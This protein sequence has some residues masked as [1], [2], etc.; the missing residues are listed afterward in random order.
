MLDPNS[1]V[2]ILVAM[3]QKRP[4]KQIALAAAFGASI[5]CVLGF[6]V[7]LS[8]AMGLSEISSTLIFA[9]PFFM[10]LSFLILG[11]CRLLLILKFKIKKEYFIFPNWF[12][13]D[14]FFTRYAGPTAPP[15]RA[16]A[17]A[18]G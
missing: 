11:Y 5:L 12:P 17:G 4:T 1:G 8:S 14:S 10:G 2:S 16:L 18:K 3:C 9:T 13:A 15:P 7:L 6:G